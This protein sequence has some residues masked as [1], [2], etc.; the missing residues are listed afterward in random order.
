MMPFS[1]NFPDT[2]VG[3]TCI[4][5]PKG[6]LSIVVGTLA[7]D[8]NTTGLTYCGVLDHLLYDSPQHDHALQG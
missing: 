5:S 6:L 7:Q 2:H 4:C 3:R 1:Q 8:E